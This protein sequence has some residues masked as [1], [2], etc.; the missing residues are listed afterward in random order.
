MHQPDVHS[1]AKFRTSSVSALPS[2]TRRSLRKKGRRK[3]RTIADDDT[4]TSPPSSFFWHRDRG[5]KSPFL[6]DRTRCW[7]RPKPKFH[8]LRHPTISREA[9]QN[10]KK[11]KNILPENKTKNTR[12]QH[13]DW[14]YL[15]RNAVFSSFIL[16]CIFLFVYFY[17]WTIAPIPI[18]Y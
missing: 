5:K 3:K 13:S 12:Y 6:Y 15:W 18:V 10:Q 4:T 17:H 2:A 1:N 9:K 8:R 11:K 14:L 7:N 16:W